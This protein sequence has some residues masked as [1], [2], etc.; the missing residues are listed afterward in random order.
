MSDVTCQCPGYPAGRCADR[1]ERRITDEAT[2][3]TIDVCGMHGLL[4]KDA[5]GYRN[6]PLPAEPTP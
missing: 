1:A 3:K 4:Y 2:G 6:E 5:D